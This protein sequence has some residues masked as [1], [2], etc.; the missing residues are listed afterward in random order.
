MPIDVDMKRAG[1]MW[2]FCCE[3]LVGHDSHD[4][5]RCN[6]LCR[7]PSWSSRS[8]F[9]SRTR[10][11]VATITRGSVSIDVRDEVSIDVRW[12][13]SVV[14]RVASVDGVSIDKLVLLS[15]DEERLPLRI[16]RSKLA[17]SDENSSGVSSL[18]L[19][20]LAKLRVSIQVIR[21]IILQML[22]SCIPDIIELN[23]LR[24][25]RSAFAF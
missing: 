21:I 23:H 1:W 5:A 7:W 17:G 8:P 18:L 14:G 11:K 25:N 12:K 10:S 16:E 22:N 19:V 6:Q 24:T 9:S 20:L 4:I 3:L 13:I 2:V 15:I